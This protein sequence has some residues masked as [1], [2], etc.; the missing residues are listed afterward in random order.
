MDETVQSVYLDIGVSLVVKNV[1]AMV[2][3][4]L[5]IKT[6]EMIYRLDQ[7]DLDKGVLNYE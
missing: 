5:V 2:M 1:I 4:L 7:T 6:Q 3:Q